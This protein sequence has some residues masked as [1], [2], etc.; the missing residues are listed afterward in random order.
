MV[1]AEPTPVPKGR[2]RRPELGAFLKARRARLRPE[3]HGIPPGDRRRTPGLR[4]EE[5][6]MLAGVGLTWYTWLEQGRPIN[7]SY[8]VLDAVARTLRMDAAERQH[9]Y[10]LADA[11]PVATTTRAPIVPEAVQV[12]VDSLDPLP[13]VLI[14]TRFDGLSANA[15]FGEVFE[16]WHGSPCI[17]RNLLWCNLAEH[18]GRDRLPDYDEV[19]PFLVARLRSNYGRHVADAEWNA[20]I[21][22]LA[23]LS[24]EF[25][26]LWARH[27]VAE[28]QVRLRRYRHPV[29][30]LAFN[31]TELDVSAVR[32][33]RILTYTPADAQTWA[34]LPR[35]RLAARHQAPVPVG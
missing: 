1:E 25:A 6:A 9:L 7:A 29:G 15:A 21:E 26:R 8:Q 18:G 11:T 32:D 33:L 14:N 17:Y 30:D 4:R 31:T 27:E 12:I 19:M 20:D 35:A 22:R 16:D 24:P 2:R 28:P 10:H 13:A 23:D 3:D 34:L 5:V